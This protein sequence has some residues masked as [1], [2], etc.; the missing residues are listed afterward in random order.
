MRRVRNAVLA[1][2]LAA[3]VALALAAV[4]AVAPEANAQEP[5]RPAPVTYAPITGGEY[6]IDT[7]H[8]TVGFAIRHYEIN[9]VSGRFREFTG[10]VNYDETDI[11]KS[12]VEFTAKVE[13]IDTGVAGRDKHLRNADFFDVEK[14]PEMT[15][16]STRVERR[17]KSFV[18]HGDLSFHGVTKPVAIPFTLTGAIKDPRGNT[19]VGINGQTTINRRD[20]GITWGKQMEGGGL[21]IGN[22]VNVT[23]QLEAVKAAPKPA[24]GQ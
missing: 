11:T 24:A 21:D 15:F 22:E 12:T 8:S 6:K 4:V 16:K 1:V 23:L 13:S 9:W 17:G 18:L 10:T 2:A 3:L 5:T 19:R 14:Y 20:F 7:A